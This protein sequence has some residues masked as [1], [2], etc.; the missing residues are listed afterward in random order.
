MSF[1]HSLKTGGSAGQAQG[2]CRAFGTS[3]DVEFGAIQPESEEYNY[4]VIVNI[5][6]YDKI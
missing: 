3:A 6:H 4:K 2:A 5:S 1:G